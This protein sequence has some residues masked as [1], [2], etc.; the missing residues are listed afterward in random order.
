VIEVV[1]FFGFLG[2]A[3]AIGL[4][5]IAT[6]GDKKY[7]FPLAVAGL[8]SGWLTGLA[9][10]Y[11]TGGLSIPLYAT[12]FPV[13][14]S[15][16]VSTLVLFYLPA[17]RISERVGSN[18]AKVAVIVFILL[19]FFVSYSSIPLAGT[20]IPETADYTGITAQSV[21]T[22]TVNDEIAEALSAEPTNQIPIEITALKNTVSPLSTTEDGIVGKYLHFKI[23]FS[24][25]RYDWAKPYIKLLIFEDKDGNGQI[26]AGDTLYA[27]TNYKVILNAGKWRANVKYVNGVPAEE[28][29][30]ATIGGEDVYLPIVHGTTS[31]WKDDTRYSFANTPE[32]YKPPN[33]MLS[34]NGN[35]LMETI[36]SFEVIPAGSSSSIEGKIYCSKEGKYLMLVEAFDARFSEPFAHWS[37]DK[38][39]SKEVIP[40]EVKPEQRPEVTIDWTVGL[41]L[42]ATCIPATILYARR[43]WQQ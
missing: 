25:S 38:P 17:P 9:W 20:T 32:R 23:T 29:F 42:T 2:L 21:R 12:T 33:D 24:V 4:W 41:I 7:L 43:W 16:I 40:F 3:T 11:T 36:Q 13:I 31:V 30:V 34:W 10:T 18:L 35:T 8:T 39:L 37:E 22:F 19:A 1:I 5:L 6:E 28:I 15:T 26:S 14:V 27:S